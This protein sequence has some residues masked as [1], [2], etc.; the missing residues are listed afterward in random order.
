[1]HSVGSTATESCA[2]ADAA[3]EVLKAS[4][5]GEVRLISPYLS[6]TV[7]AALIANRP[8][9][10][11]TDLAACFEAYTDEPLASILSAHCAQIRQRDRVHAK[12]VLTDNAALL[13]SA[14]LTDSGF[15]DR[16]E[17]GC[18]LFDVSQV[19][20]LR[21]WFDD[22]WAAAR[23]VTQLDIGR[24]AETGRS[25]TPLAGEAAGSPS[26]C[27]AKSLCHH[28]SLGW[29]SPH[30]DESSGPSRSSHRAPIEPR[31]WKDL[32]TQLRRLTKSPAQAEQVLKLLAQALEISG[33]GVGDQRLH[34]NFGRR[35]MSITIVQ[36]YVA[37][38]DTEGHPEFGFILTDSELAD[39]VAGQIPGAR[40]SFFRRAGS[41]DASALHVPVSA[42]SAVPESV[43][44][45]WERAIR[46]ECGRRKA[47]GSPYRSS[48][49]HLTREA[50]YHVLREPPERA[51]LVADAHPEGDRSNHTLNFERT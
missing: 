28:R 12:L 43:L 4:P 7:L 32:V 19:R 25:S 31:D 37:W 26:A 14:N 46:H 10:L 30:A 47:D 27:V 45:D 24:A 42:L 9:R 49:R 40:V 39:S 34:L 38:C 44:S 18:V 29:M 8:F 11:I 41:D 23:P 33:L 17:L 5:S 13:G 1:M 3:R 22:L 48:F 35:P 16:D 20:T 15:A 51:R 2:F 21:A 6:H 36:R 50:L